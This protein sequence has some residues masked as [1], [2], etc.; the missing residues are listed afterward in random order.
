MAI[1]AEK[2]SKAFY[3]LTYIKDSN[4]ELQMEDGF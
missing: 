3:L 1:L 4:A 2:W